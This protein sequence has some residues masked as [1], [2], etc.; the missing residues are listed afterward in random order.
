MNM[1]IL[2]VDI[3]A[4]MDYEGLKLPKHVLHLLQQ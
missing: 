4:I 1:L 3:T 2:V